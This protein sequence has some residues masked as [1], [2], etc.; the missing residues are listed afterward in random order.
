[1]KQL[2]QI[3]RLN[4]AA[5]SAREMPSLFSMCIM[6]PNLKEL[7]LSDNCLKTIQAE[8]L[9]KCFPNLTIIKLKG[10][11]LTDVEEIH[12]LDKL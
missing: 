7:D 11:R 10:N 12:T 3:K 6:F 5:N 4:L 2:L 1:M 8:T 9:I